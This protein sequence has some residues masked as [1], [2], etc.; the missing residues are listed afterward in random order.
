MV[1]KVSIFEETFIFY[2]WIWQ[3]K[4]AG[5]ANCNL[6]IKSPTTF[7]QSGI[8]TFI[9][10]A[11]PPFSMRRYYFF[12]DLYTIHPTIISAAVI[13]IPNAHPPSS[14]FICCQRVSSRST[15]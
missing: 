13:I 9:V 8:N 4:Y 7:R 15:G 14:S 2:E 6:F 12:R 5:V 3:P 1:G 10:L 11:E